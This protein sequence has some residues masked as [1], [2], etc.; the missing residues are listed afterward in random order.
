MASLNDVLD[1][2]V[3][4]ATAGG[5]AAAFKW[6]LIGGVVLAVFALL[7]LLVLLFFSPVYFAVGLVAIV[8]AVVLWQ[9]G[10]SLV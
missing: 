3:E 2:A 1:A 4:I 9:R 10:D 8:A 7:F 6:K 5:E